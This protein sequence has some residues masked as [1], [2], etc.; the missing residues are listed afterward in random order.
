LI[1]VSF[2]CYAFGGYYYFDD[3]LGVHNYDLPYATVLDYL[4]VLFSAVALIISIAVIPNNRIVLKVIGILLSLV[5]LYLSV[6]WV[7][8][9]LFI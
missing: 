9:T 8:E 7:L 5:M 6:F 1:F 3:S 4:S 2:I